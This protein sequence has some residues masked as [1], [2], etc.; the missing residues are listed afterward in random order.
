MYPRTR[1][2]TRAA[3]V[4]LA[5][6]ASA[7]VCRASKLQE[8]SLIECPAVLANGQLDSGNTTSANFIFVI[9]T[10]NNKFHGT[11]NAT[12]PNA[13]GKTLKFHDLTFGFSGVIKSTYTVHANGT[14][15]VTMSGIASHL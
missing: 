3:I 15:K 5:Y 10:S 12:V 9:D 6:L 8:E 7:A 2:L 1:H 14:A 13:S 4:I 11:A